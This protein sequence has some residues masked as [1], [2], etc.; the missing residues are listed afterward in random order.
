MKKL[1]I[2]LSAISLFLLGCA[3]STP[4]DDGDGLDNA[5]VSFTSSVQ[6]SRWQE[7][8]NY[9]TPDEARQIGTSDGYEFLPE[10]Q[11]AASR[12]PLS[13]LRKAGLGVDS[14]GRLVGIKAVMDETNERYKVSEEQ[15]KVGT[16]LKQMEDDRIKRRLEE[17]QK[18]LQEEEATAHQEPTVE[19]LTNRLTDDE[20][21][22]YGSTGELLAPE[23][24]RDDNSV[25]TYN[26]AYGK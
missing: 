13:T 15:A 25:E 6:S 8:L 3:S 5:L 9:V 17:G 23:A 16:N 26:G 10:Y 22:K 2:L 21:R 18:I 4:K 12:L 7:A 1:L 19:V 20:K 24:S 11:T 14:E